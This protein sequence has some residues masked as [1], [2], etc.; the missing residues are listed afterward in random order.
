MKTFLFEQYGYYP[1]TIINNL[2][3]IDDWCF[4]LLKVDLNEKDIET[5]CLYLDNVRNIFNEKG[6]F[7]IKTRNDKY[8]SVYDNDKYVLVSVKKSYMTINDLS[9][10]HYNLVEVDKKIE[11][12]K[13]LNVWMSRMENVENECINS[14]RI[15]SV[16][17][18]H[19]LEVAMYVLGLAQN[20][21][22]YLSECIEDYGIQLSGLTI[23]HKRMNDLNSFD[24][25]NPFNFIVDHPIRDL[26]E[27]YKNDYLSFNDFCEMLNY[28]K[29]N[30][31][32]AT[33]IISRILYPIK[34]F[35]LL[36]DNVS[37]KEIKFKI[38]YNIEK[39]F[40]KL[41]KIYL[42][43]KDKY[44]IRPIDWLE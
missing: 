9:L 11:L 29:I 31:M 25:F 27:L 38:E 28:Y 39:E 26:C 40:I 16:Y 24:F 42:F 18:S 41:K 35:D 22:Q 8:I 36:E 15:D 43:I 1:Q 2:F 23:A 17:Y 20:A 33:I 37:K 44:K 5:I 13:I 32:I 14:L 4:K 12:D 34:V 7:I 10:F 21:I 3:Y 19:N 6:A 30:S